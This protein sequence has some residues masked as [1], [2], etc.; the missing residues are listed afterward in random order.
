VKLV[1]IKQHFSRRERYSRFKAKFDKNGFSQFRRNLINPVFFRGFCELAKHR[2][3]AIPDT[4]AGNLIR[5]QELENFEKLVHNSSQK[6]RH[7]RQ[8][9]FSCLAEL[10]RMINGS[11]RHRSEILENDSGKPLRAPLGSAE[12]E[13]TVRRSVVAVL[14][15][16]LLFAEP[17]FGTFSAFKHPGDII[18]LEKILQGMLHVIDTQTEWGEIKVSVSSSAQSHSIRITPGLGDMFED[19]GFSSYFLEKRHDD[20]NSDDDLAREGIEGG[21]IGFFSRLVELAGG[22]M[23]TEKGST[24]IIF[25]NERGSLAGRV[26]SA[27]SQN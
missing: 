3:D 7:W 14:R 6:Y 15:K 4:T 10:A 8:N 16:S 11:K 19:R 27:F 26:L 24:C 18:L 5:N 21:Q 25:G 20:F 17:K 13:E 1:E 23:R 9:G 22:R 2:V 12:V